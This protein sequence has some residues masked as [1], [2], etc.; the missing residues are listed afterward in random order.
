MI[1]ILVLV[2][3]LIVLYL[4]RSKFTLTTQ[5]TPVIPVTPK[6]EEKI[7]ALDN[8]IQLTKDLVNSQ[9]LVVKNAQEYINTVNK[10]NPPNLELQ[11]ISQKSLESAK[12]GLDS[13]KKQL[14]ELLKKKI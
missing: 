11:K 8:A 2:L 14:D 6:K 12:N 13:S 1:I 9:T 4:N 7:S 5:V 3:V 10:L